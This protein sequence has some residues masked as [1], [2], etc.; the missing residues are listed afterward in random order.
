MVQAGGQTVPK[1]T[2]LL[3]RHLQQQ[4]GPTDNPGGEARQCEA[5]GV[6]PQRPG[7]GRRHLQGQTVSSEK[8]FCMD[9]GP[10]VPSTSKY[11]NEARNPDSYV[12]P[13]ISKC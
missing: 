7:R 8:L 12:K 5:Q 3:Y 1:Q 2:L 11:W 10:H 6:G 9:T 13:P 4:E